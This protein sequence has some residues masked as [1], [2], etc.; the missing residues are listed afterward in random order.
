MKY[1][2][3]SNKTENPFSLK[4]NEREMTSKTK[5][6]STYNLTHPLIP[7]QSAPKSRVP[8]RAESPKGQSARKGRVPGRAECSKPEKL[9]FPTT[10]RTT[11]MTITRFRDDE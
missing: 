2:Y 4:D 10:T 1:S 7:R 11:T 8:K 9:K 3:L 5:P 6:M